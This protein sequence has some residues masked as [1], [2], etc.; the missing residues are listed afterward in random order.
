VRFLADENFPRTAAE[1]LR[2][3]G[4]DVL[5]VKSASPGIPDERLIEAAF[6]QGRVILT[7]DKDFG[8]W[9]FREGKASAG[10]ILFRLD[11]PTTRNRMVDWLVDAVL[12]RSDWEG[13][14]S[15]VGVDLRVRQRRLTSP[16]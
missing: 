10:V 7:F 4:H 16:A 8:D 5:S 3:A 14:F 15:S 11:A 1:R 6:Q 9:V 12:S 13:H 2:A